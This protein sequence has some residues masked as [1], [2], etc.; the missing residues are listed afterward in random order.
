MQGRVEPGFVLRENT[1]VGVVAEAG[2]P[3][4]GR[5]FY[6]EVFK[7][8]KQSIDGCYDKNRVKTAIGV[9]ML[10]PPGPADTSNMS[11]E[12][13]QERLERCDVP[14]SCASRLFQQLATRCAASWLSPCRTPRHRRIIDWVKVAGANG[15]LNESVMGV[16]CRLNRRPSYACAGKVGE[17]RSLRQLC[18]DIKHP[19]PHRYRNGANTTEGRHDAKVPVVPLLRLTG[20]VCACI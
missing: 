1:G 5:S 13:R 7:A 10:V 6:E 18:N 14:P 16:N 9:E 20:F 15:E 2:Y 19:S 3:A 8:K 11:R 12:R 17:L 4:D